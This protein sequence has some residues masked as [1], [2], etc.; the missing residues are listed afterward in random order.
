VQR[1]HALVAQAGVEGELRLLP[2]TLCLGA[3]GAAGFGGDHRAAARIVTRPLLHPAGSDQR[4]QVAGERGGI[5]LHAR[6]QIAGPQRAEQHH[7]REQRV[8]RVL[9][10][11][12]RHVGVVVTRHRTAELAQ[13]Q[14]R[15]ALR[16]DS[17]EHGDYCS[18]NYCICK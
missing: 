15:A 1:E 10:P 8:L 16:L 14:V 4:L 17:I 18:C 9:Q 12:G 13:L 3:L 6:G 2:C 5:D 7:V 11:G